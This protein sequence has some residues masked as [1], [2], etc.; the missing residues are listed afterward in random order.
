MFGVLP[1]QSILANSFAMSRPCG[2][3][4][5]QLALSRLDATSHSAGRA[6]Q[7]WCFYKFCWL[8]ILDSCR[9]RGGREGV[10]RLQAPP[11]TKTVNVPLIRRRTHHSDVGVVLPYSSASCM[12]GAM[13]TITGG[14][15]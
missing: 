13:S 5:C 15:H 10:V 3:G 4:S 11:G 9:F 8:C 1:V 14:I 2:G 12:S 7:V 6:H